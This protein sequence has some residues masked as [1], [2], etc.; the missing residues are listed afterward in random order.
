MIEYWQDLTTTDFGGGELEASL[1]LHLR[2]D[3]VRHEA[4][5]DFAPPA[6]KPDNL[7]GPEQPVGCAWMSQDLNPS[8]LGSKT[9]NDGKMVSSH[10]PR[11][12]TRN[13]RPLPWLRRCQLINP[14]HPKATST[15]R[16][17]QTPPGHCY[18]R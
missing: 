9:R 10:A 2:A 13:T 15:Q 7:L 3:V 14:W 11:G 18:W 5:R 8:H 4:L 16:L 12:R 17:R 1:L 6:A